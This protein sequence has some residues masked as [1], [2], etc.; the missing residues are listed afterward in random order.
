MAIERT[1]AT[2]HV[3]V[4]HT[5]DWQNRAAVDAGLLKAFRPKVETWNTTFIMP[6]HEF[7]QRLKVIAQLSLSRVQH[8]HRVSRPEVPSGGLIVPVDDDDWFSPELAIRLQEAIDPSFRGYYWTRHILE[9]ERH[10]R[11]FKGWLRESITRKVIFATNNYA[12]SDVPDLARLAQN[13]VAA[14]EYFQAR[15]GHRRYIRAALSIHNRSLASQTALGWFRPTI[16]R[17]ELIERFER[18]RTLYART[19]LSRALRWAEPYVS[20]MCEL[21]ADLKLR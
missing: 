16:T 21:M 12:L 8:V 18:Y 5:L 10:R 9:P 15:P 20:L 1:A 14:S 17:D 11:R 2:I 19:H 7:R 6:Y 3:W 13:H 4:R